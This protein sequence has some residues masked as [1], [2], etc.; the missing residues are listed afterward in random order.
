VV[1][2]A[3][4]IGFFGLCLELDSSYTAAVKWLLREMFNRLRSRNAC[5][6]VDAPP[7][8]SFW[9]V[10]S[11][12][13]DGPAIVYRIRSHRVVRLNRL[14]NKRGEFIYAVIY[15][16]IAET[17]RNVAQDQAGSLIYWRGS[18]GVKI[19]CRRWTCSA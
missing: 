16:T 10:L 5:A 15:S 19:E 1:C 9:S 3:T 17:S 14:D 12:V 8:V 13:Y 11:F 6:T 7:D 18:G 4:V 2:T